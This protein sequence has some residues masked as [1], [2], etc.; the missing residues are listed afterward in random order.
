M[1]VRGGVYVV[2]R[3]AIGPTMAKVSVSAL[4]VD[5]ILTGP[6][7][8]VSA[9]QYLGRLLNEIS[10]IAASIVSRR[11]E[12]FRGSFWGRGHGIF[13]AEQHQ[14][15]PR[16]ERQGPP[17]HADHH[18]DGVGP[19][20]LVPDNATGAGIRPIA[21]RPRD[22][23][24]Q[25]IRDYIGMAV[26]HVLGAVTDGDDDGAF[27]HSLLAM[28]GFETLAQVYREIAYPKLKNLKITANIVCFYALLST[29]LISLFAVMI[30]P[31]TYPAAVL[32]QPHRRT[33]DESCRSRPAEIDLPHV[34]GDRRRSDSFRRREYFDHW[35]ERCS[36]PRCRRWRPT[37]VVSP[38][39]DRYGT[40]FRIINM[41]AIPAGPHHHWQPRRC[42]AARRSLCVW[43]CLE[44]LPERDWVCLRCGFSAAIRSIRP[45]LISDRKVRNPDRPRRHGSDAVFGCHRE[46]VYQKDCDDIRHF[47]YGSAVRHCLSFPSGST[48]GG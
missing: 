33:F 38:P 36:K 6:I 12:L 31:D 30:I 28:S 23:E 35:R 10:E 34:C 27:G 4:V 13:L 2:V 32:R 14:R 44:L 20:G 22:A 24:H 40:T 8:S 47:L 45:R 37:R 5:Y 11:P 25:P 26:W 15:H 9:G 16:I 48:G 7:S 19:A 18:C 1:F 42:S 41:I 43:R 39:A 21:A 29:G 3:D 46:P 17:H